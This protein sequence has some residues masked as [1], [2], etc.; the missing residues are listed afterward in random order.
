MTKPTAG[1]LQAAF[2]ALRKDVDASG[3][4]Q[5][6]DDDKVRQLATD[7]T[8]AVVNAAVA[9]KPQPA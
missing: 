4:G 2:T 5:F 1:Q 6:V 8:V 9:E 7:V 3:Y